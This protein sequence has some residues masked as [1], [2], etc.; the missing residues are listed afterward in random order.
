MEQESTTI[1]SPNASQTTEDDTLAPPQTALAHLGQRLKKEREH[2]H[3]SIDEVAS[4]LKITG[5]LVRAIENGDSTALPHPVYAKGF[6]K[7]YSTLM[8]LEPES[9][10]AALEELDNTDTQKTKQHITKR[11]RS[12]VGGWIGTFFSVFLLLAALSFSLFWFRE[13]LFALWD[14]FSSPNTIQTAPEVSQTLP[15]QRT[16]DNEKTLSEMSNPL[17]LPAVEVETTPVLQAATVQQHGDA[18]KKNIT[19]TRASEHSI[20]KINVSGQNISETDSSETSTQPV[21]TADN[22]PPQERQHQKTIHPSETSS[23]ATQTPK[24]PPITEP[25]AT[26]H[27]ATEK[28]QHQVILT[29]LADCWVHS[30]ADTTVT[31]ELSL[32][33]GEI[34][35]L[36]FQKQLE[37]KLGN[38]GG[39]RIVYN[40]K[41]LPPPGKSGQVITLHFPIKENS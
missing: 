7:T 8:A 27:S 3:C 22:L 40:G 20:S 2:R 33:K 35:A 10:T 21:A 25:Q 30:T 32:V 6:I 24:Q 17:P 9:I 26:A 16:L 39:V 29:G 1:S 5:R 19:E 37:L 18:T 36:S 14:R 41:T 28:Q 4:L 12:A 38:A 13:P 31:R 23:S 34:F 11:R 15:P